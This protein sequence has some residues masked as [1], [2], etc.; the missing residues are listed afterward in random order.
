MAKTLYGQN[1]VGIK[2][3]TTVVLQTMHIMSIIQAL[4]KM[5]A[6]RP[7]FELLL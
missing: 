6:D 3:C 4:L 5:F 2:C 7:F 1:S